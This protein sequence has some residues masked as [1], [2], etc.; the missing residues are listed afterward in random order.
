MQLD[1]RVREALF[2]EEL[3]HREAVIALEL[4]N[5]PVLFI[6]DEIAVACKLLYKLDRFG[7]KARGRRG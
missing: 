6:G 5:D 2:S 4:E 7:E 3:L 1:G